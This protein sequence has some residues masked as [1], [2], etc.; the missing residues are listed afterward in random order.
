MIVLAA[1]VV[2]KLFVDET[3]STDAAR[4]VARYPLL[5]APEI[6]AV[7][8]TAA[9]THKAR[10]GE[11]DRPTAER[12]LVSWWEFLALGNL[13]LTPDR[14]LLPEAAK[15]SL[16]LALSPADCLYLTLA[17]AHGLPL[18]TADASLRDA[19]PGAVADV[20]LLTDFA[21]GAA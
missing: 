11:I 3:G 4:L 8:V 16:T 9:V 12:A 20:R 7:E 2:T 18:I 17:A 19:V 6:I 21:L 13:H 5:L 14:A 15:L 10:E 1:C